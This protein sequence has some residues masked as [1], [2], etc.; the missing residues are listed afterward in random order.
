LDAS[1]K[2]VGIVGLNRDVTRHK[3]AEEELKLAKEAAEAASRVKSE[4]IAN[5]SHEIRTP[6]RL[7]MMSRSPSMARR[8]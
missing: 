8:L 6:T 2:I 4:F 3:Q 1:G 5:M 7:A